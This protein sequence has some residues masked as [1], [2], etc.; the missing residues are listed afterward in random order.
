MGAITST[1]TFLLSPS[2]EKEQHILGGL[3][4]CQETDFI[5]EVVGERHD[6]EHEG[7]SSAWTFGGM[8]VAR[9]KGADQTALRHEE[10][11]SDTGHPRPGGRW[12]WE[13]RGRGNRWWLATGQEKHQVQGSVG[14]DTDSGGRRSVGH[15]IPRYLLRHL[16][17]SQFYRMSES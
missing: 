1:C 14:L 2:L 8:E 9:A 5:L 4:K 12:P 6:K 16:D 17:T 11:K 10:G 7:S 13:Q 3:H 15:R